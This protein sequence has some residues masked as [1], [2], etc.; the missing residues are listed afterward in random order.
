MNPIKITKV[1]PVLEQLFAIHDDRGGIPEWVIKKYGEKL[2]K[3]HYGQNIS[4]DCPHS[5][6]FQKDNAMQVAIRFSHWGK[7]PNAEQVTEESAKLQG[8]FQK[9][10]DSWKA[11]ED[12]SKQK[13]IEFG[14][15]HKLKPLPKIPNDKK[16]GVLRAK[17]AANLKAVIENMERRFLHSQQTGQY[18]DCRIDLLDHPY[19]VKVYKALIETPFKPYDFPQLVQRADTAA[20]D[21]IPNAVWDIVEAI[22]EGRFKMYGEALEIQQS[23]VG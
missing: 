16:I 13:E 14:K 6:V 11:D 5:F 10:V 12:A 3:K 9:I 1:S 23:Y 21:A 15:N 18:E 17:A 7:A 19:A 4:F 20:R 2:L 8:I 22:E